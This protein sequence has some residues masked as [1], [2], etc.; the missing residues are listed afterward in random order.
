MCYFH[1][2]R[3]KPKIHYFHYIK[4]E[5]KKKEKAICTIYKNNLKHAKRQIQN[6]ISSISQ[7]NSKCS[8]STT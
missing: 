6:T 8:I 7:T 1:Y 3:N 2:I 5:K 4:K